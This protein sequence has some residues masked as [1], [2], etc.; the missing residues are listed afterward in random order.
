MH[1]GHIFLFFHL[2]YRISPH[3]LP[4][5]QLPA[6]YGVPHYSVS[7]T[8]HFV[9]WR[10]FY[11]WKRWDPYSFSQSHNTLHLHNEGGGDALLARKDECLGPGPMFTLRNHRGKFLLSYKN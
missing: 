6:V 11:L 3:S 10:N 9:R 7:R 5:R 2:Y 8:G 4:A 1:F